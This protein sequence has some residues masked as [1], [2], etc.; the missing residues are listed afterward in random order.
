[1]TR[2]RVRV[3]WAQKGGRVKKEER[4][5]R[6]TPGTQHVCWSAHLADVFLDQLRTNDA[7]KRGICAVGHGSGAELSRRGEGSRGRVRKA[8][9][10]LLRTAPQGRRPKSQTHRLAGAGRAV[11]QDTLGRVNTEVDKALGLKEEKKKKR[12][13]GEG[14]CVGHY[15]LRACTAG[16]LTCSKG[17]STTSR[18][19]W[20]W[21]LQPP[22]S[23]YVTSGLSSTWM[24]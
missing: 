21:S 23:A 24:R 15:M 7:N 9:N 19:F 13:S 10:V 2:L 8:E 3:R 16:P 18:S 12:D 14:Q 20:I 1:M 17:I 6:G 5:S 11:Q 4:D 22:T